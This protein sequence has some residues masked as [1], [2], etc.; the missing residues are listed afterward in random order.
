MLTGQDNSFWIVSGRQWGTEKN[1]L[2]HHLWNPFVLGVPSLRLEKR[3]CLRTDTVATWKRHRRM[4][5]FV[6]FFFF[7]QPYATLWLAYQIETL[8]KSPN[9]GARFDACLR[10]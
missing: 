7:Y 5:L 10:K 1:E 2:D 9:I 6:F 3:R 4:R 8:A